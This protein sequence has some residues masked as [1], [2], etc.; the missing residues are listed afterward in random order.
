MYRLN[1]QL[2]LLNIKLTKDGKTIDMYD[3]PFGV[4]GMLNGGA[5][6]ISSG[7]N[8]KPFPTSSD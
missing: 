8:S 2:R 1:Y 6:K 7:R 5:G 4:Y 3:Q